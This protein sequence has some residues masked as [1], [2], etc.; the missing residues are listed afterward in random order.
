MNR[1]PSELKLMNGNPGKR[2][3]RDNEPR[4]KSIIPKMPKD[5]DRDAAKTWKRLAPALHKLGLLTELDGDALAHLCQIRSRVMVIHQAIKDNQAIKG[6][7]GIKNNDLL[8]DTEISTDSEGREHRRVR[9]S[10]YTKL[11]KQYYQLFRLYASDFGLTPRGRA[12]LAVSGDK[13]LS[14][15]EN[16]LD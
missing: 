13:D 9:V 15:F 7:Q 5:I 11:E 8:L 3:I 10:L 16:L 2:P 1:K 4:P 12:G 6:N 14:D